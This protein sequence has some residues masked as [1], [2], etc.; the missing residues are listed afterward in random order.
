MMVNYGHNMFIVQATVAMLVNYDRNMFI[1]KPL[2][3]CSIMI[4]TCL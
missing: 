1:V 2:S 3:L 4:I